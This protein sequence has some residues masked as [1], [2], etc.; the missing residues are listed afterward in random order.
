MSGCAGLPRPDC[1]PSPKPGEIGT[2]CGFHGPEDLEYV[3]KS[4]LIVV[5]NLRLPGRLGQGGG[6]L[7]GFEP[8]SEDPQVLR[9]WP[10]GPGKESLVEPEP[11]LGDPSCTEPPPPEAFAPHGITSLLVDGERQLL[12]A[13][14][15]RVGGASREAVEIF[16]MRGRGPATVLAWKACIPTPGEIQ[17]NDVVVDLDGR[18]VVS[19]YQPSGSIRHTL[20]AGLFGSKT[21][22]VLTWTPVAGWQPVPGTEASM[23]NGIALT[24]RGENVMFAE[25]MTGKVRRVPLDGGG[26]AIELDLGGNPDNFTETPRGTLLLA[27]HTDG[28]MFMLCAFGRSPCETG[29]SVSEIDPDTLAVREVFRHDGTKVGAIATALEVDG[30]L[31]VGSVFDDRIGVVRFDGT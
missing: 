2:I 1:A 8:G 21:G 12:Y 29:W 4:G 16:E 25:M 6:F 20:A 18:L 26:G 14:G 17:A 19:N 28:A 9:L 27:T 22:N 31:Y 24:R 30:T 5:S 7:S 13:I 3:R 11:S 23:A 15:H 10:A